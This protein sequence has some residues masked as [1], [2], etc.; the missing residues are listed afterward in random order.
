MLVLGITG[1]IGMGKSTAAAILYKLGIESVDSDALAREA[2]GIGKPGYWEIL[3]RFRDQSIVDTDGTINRGRLAKIVFNDSG[4]LKD[5][6][7]I[8][9]PRIRRAWEE[10]LDRQRESG[11][12]AAAV[13]IPLLFEK[14]YDSYFDVAIAVGCG[15]GTQKQRLLS[16][17]W[18]DAQIGARNAAQLALVDK[19]KRAKYVIWTEGAIS[20]HEKQWVATLANLGLTCCPA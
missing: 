12:R 4:A 16:R 2:S 3:E 1:G 14:A 15:P 9:H 18:D 11:K 7:A 19:M 8:L 17:G 6:E 5:L 20:T 13:L 10:W